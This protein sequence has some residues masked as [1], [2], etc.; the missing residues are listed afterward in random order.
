VERSSLEG[1]DTIPYTTDSCLHQNK[2]V[3]T[4]QS[5]AEANPTVLALLGDNLYNDASEC[6]WWH[7]DGECTLTQ[8]AA[9]ALRRFR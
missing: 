6:E 8:R 5:M 3:R 4:L 7:A 1:H 2:D 9:V